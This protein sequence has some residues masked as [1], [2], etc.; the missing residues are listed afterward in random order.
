MTIPKR[1]TPEEAATKRDLFVRFIGDT[2]VAPGFAANPALESAYFAVAQ[3]WDDEALDAVY[4]EVLF[5]EL[6]EPDFEAG[7]SW[8]THHQHGITPDLV[9]LPTIGP[10]MKLPEANP[11]KVEPIDEFDEV[12]MFAAFCKE[13][14]NQDAEPFENYIP[15]ALY[16]RSDQ[17]SRYDVSIVGEMLR[18]WLDGVQPLADGDNDV[19][20]L[21][22]HEAI[23]GKEVQAPSLGLNTYEW[24]P[25][26]AVTK[27]SFLRRILGKRT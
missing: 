20:S 21:I 4:H 17:A 25:I 11:S 26:V 1:L 3:F 27:P 18:P 13:G 14:G 12:S 5:S 19:D 16:R 23:Y 2:T 8:E 7:M 22:A 24:A 6:D 10:S 9:N 15:Y